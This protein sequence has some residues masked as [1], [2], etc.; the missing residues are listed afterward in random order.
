MTSHLVASHY[1]YATLIC[2]IT[3]TYAN[4][5]TVHTNLKIYYHNIYLSVC[6]CLF[7]FC[8]C[9]YIYILQLLY[10]ERKER[11]KDDSH[12]VTN[13]DYSV[14]SFSSSSKFI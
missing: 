5:M 1:E 12:V 10:G 9:V 6:M 14:A 13:V 7:F 4:L 11:K 8:V 2:V 3:L